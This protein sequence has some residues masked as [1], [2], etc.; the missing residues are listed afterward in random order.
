MR[1]LCARVSFSRGMPGDSA[2]PRTLGSKVPSLGAPI[3]GLIAAPVLAATIFTVGASRAC[4]QTGANS[5]PN[6]LALR[7]IALGSEAVT[8]TNFDLKRDAGKFHLLGTVCFVAPVNGKVTGAVFVGDGTF[9]L[10]PPT[11]TERK[12]L[13]YLTK[14][15]EFSEKFER[16]VLRFTD[17][18][19]DE[20]K[21]AGTPASGGCDAGPRLCPP[22]RP[23][24]REP[25]CA[26]PFGRLPDH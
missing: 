20:I 6:Y 23:G 21:K 2:A 22:R 19:Y 16:L 24:R 15:D 14:E 12:S 17:S 13:K 5:D 10:T 7:N 18:T 25:P 26:A 8:V 4:A 1:D 3:V 9:V 11:A